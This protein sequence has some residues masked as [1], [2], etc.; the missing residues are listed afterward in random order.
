MAEKTKVCC[1]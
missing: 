1:F